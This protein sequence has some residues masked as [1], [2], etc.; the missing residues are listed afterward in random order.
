MNA[1][2]ST[3]KMNGWGTN[4]EVNMLQTLMLIQKRANEVELLKQAIPLNI[5]NISAL[6]NTN[7]LLYLRL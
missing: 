2:G 7:Y 3:S 4:E 6:E 1:R 5:I